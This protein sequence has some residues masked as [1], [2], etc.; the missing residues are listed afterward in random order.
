[1]LDPRITNMFDDSKYR[2]HNVIYADELK[3]QKEKIDS[4]DLINRFALSLT[5]NVNPGAKKVAV[6]VD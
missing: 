3:H 2:T 5:S 6:E 4:N 1:V